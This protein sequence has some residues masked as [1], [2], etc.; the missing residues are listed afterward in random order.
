[1]NSQE[2]KYEKENN[3]L[4]QWKVVSGKSYDLKVYFLKEYDE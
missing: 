2:F 1:M 4:L 3:Y